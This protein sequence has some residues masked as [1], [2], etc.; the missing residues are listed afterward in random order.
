MA[1]QL[2]N[3][4]RRL[5]AFRSYYTDSPN[6]QRLA[7]LMKNADTGDIGALCELQEEMEGRNAIIQGVFATRRKAVTGLEWDIQPPAGMEEDKAA[8]EAADYCRETLHGIDDFRSALRY[9]ASAIGPNVAMVETIWE[10]LRPVAFRQVPGGR[11]IQNLQEGTAIKLVTE[12]NQQGME[13]P[14]WKFIVHIP[15]SRIDWPQRVNLTRATVPFFIAMHYAHA[16]WLAFSEI[17]GQPWRVAKTSGEVPSDEVKGEIIDMLKNVGS[18]GWGFF[19]GNVDL[20]LLESAKSEGPQPKLLQWCKDNLSILVL[21]QTL[22]TDIGPV[23]SRAAAEVHDNV[24]LDLLMS[25]L[26]DEAATLRQQLL[27]PMTRFRFPGRDMPIPTFVREVEERKD[28]EGARLMLEQLRYAHDAGL[29]VV[30]REAYDRL[31]LTMPDDT[32]DKKESTPVTFN[33]LTLAI[34]RATNIGD[35]DLVNALRRRISKIIGEILPD[36]TELERPSSIPTSP[37]TPDTSP[38][39]PPPDSGNDNPQPATAREKVLNV[40]S[41]TWRNVED[42][43]AR[44]GLNVAQVRGVVQH[45]KSDLYVL[46]RRVGKQCEYRAK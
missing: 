24:R 33:E 46:S 10:S 17:F 22:T 11:L 4:S 12:E 43:V 6:P 23:G 42:I 25:D 31:G 30:P 37:T 29:P 2:T 28:V 27:A 19:T 20:Q 26:A 39:G 14:P 34:E 1:K 5:D 13:L 7:A 45:S 41:K 9:L 40:I 38:D 16:D 18:D 15:D 3:Y 36:L 8:L 21:G 32:E 35:L 44:T